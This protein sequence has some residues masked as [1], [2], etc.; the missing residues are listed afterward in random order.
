MSSSINTSFQGSLIP[1]EFRQG[2]GPTCVPNQPKRYRIT[3]TLRL[4]QLD[5]S[6]ACSMSDYRGHHV[7]GLVVPPS[8]Y[9]DPIG[10]KFF[11]CA[12]R[13][14]IG[15]HALTELCECC[16]LFIGQRQPL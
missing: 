4:G 15:E 2:V 16:G 8:V 1:A 11:Q 7:Y 9:N 14:E 13:C 5:F 10:E 12:F 6:L 3:A